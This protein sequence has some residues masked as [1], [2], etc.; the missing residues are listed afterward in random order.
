M[1]FITGE[2]GIGKTALVEAFIEQHAGDDLWVAQGRCIEQYGTSEAH[3]PI[4]EA[5]EQLA[6]Q[7]GSGAFIDAFARYAPTWLAHL[8]WLARVVDAA[9]MERA[10]ADATH[11]RML[12]ELAH[13]L[14]VLSMGRTVVIWLEDLHWS[15]PSSLDVISFPSGASM[16]L[17]LIVARP[18]DATR[19]ASALHKIVLRLLQRGCTGA[20]SDHQPEIGDLRRRFSGRLAC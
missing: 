17:L 12:R 5:L 14:D 11:Q 2:P 13:A 20:A 18:A 1:V 10:V 6:R 19:G 15:D 16:R 9:A 8:P 3:L 7:V 4:L